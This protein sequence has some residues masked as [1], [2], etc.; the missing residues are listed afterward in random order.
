MKMGKKILRYGIITILVLFST[1]FI[2]LKYNSN[3]NLKLEFASNNNAKASIS[4]KDNKHSFELLGEGTYF[5][6]VLNNEG[7]KLLYSSG[8]DIYEFDLVKNDV[9]QITALGSCYNPVYSYKDNNIIAFARNDGIYTMDIKSKST[10]KLVSSKESEVTFAKPNFTLEGDIIYFRVSVFPRENG[11]GFEEKDPS[12]HRVSKD[13]EKDEKIL[14]GYNPVLSID[15]EKLLYEVGQEIYLMDMKTSHKKLIDKGKYASFSKD[16]NF[17]SYAKFDRNTVPYRKVKSKTD[18]LF[19]DKEYSNIYVADINDTK[20]KYKVTKEEF[21]N[22]DKELKDWAEDVNESTAE[23][24]FL[25]VS[26]M[27][28]FDSAWGKNNDKLYVSA[29]N[30]DKGEFELLQFDIDKK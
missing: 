8:D 20:G 17:I 7:T 18:N 13:G 3:K 27:A 9:K 19:V 11:H 28:Y 26:K 16:G 2:S 23:Q 25:V 24:H 5:T 10:I 21:E 29:Y 30:S 14:N 4:D 1:L 6:P 22:T 12:I 15:G